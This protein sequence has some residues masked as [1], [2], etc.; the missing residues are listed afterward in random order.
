MRTGPLTI[1]Q[2]VDHLGV[3]A[4]AVRQKLSRLQDAE[5]VDRTQAADGRGRPSHQ[6]DLTEK[7]R[8]SV[9]DNL[10]DLACALWHEIQEIPDVEL[11]NSLVKGAI[12]RLA[13][14]Y[15]SRVVGKSIEDRLDSV[16]Q[17]FVERDIPITVD[18]KNGLPVLRI[19][20]C[21]YPDLANDNHAVCEMEKQL[22]SQVI[23]ASVDL[24]QCRRQG[25]S[26]CSFEAVG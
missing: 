25:D 23:G 19:L 11:R 1:Q 3:T 16:A 9:G 4:T 26:C 20:Q 22:F 13:N 6:Y 18:N 8:R 14:D 5:L 17:I 2:L 7:G 10:A 12:R 21:P 24:C 15:S